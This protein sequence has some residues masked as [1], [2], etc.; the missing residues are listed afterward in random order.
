[1]K[2]R[3]VALDRRQVSRER[4]KWPRAGAQPCAA[5]SAGDWECTSS[6]EA[7]AERRIELPTAS[8]Y[9]AG[10]TGPGDHRSSCGGDIALGGG[11]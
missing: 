11:R 8:V 5:Q 7:T 2:R 10:P 4:G 9:E 6:S 1:M 3:R